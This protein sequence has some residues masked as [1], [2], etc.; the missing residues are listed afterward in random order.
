MNEIIDLW[1]DFKAEKIRSPKTIL[2][3]QADLLGKKTNNILLCELYFYP[4]SSKLNLIEFDFK[5]KAPNL[6]GYTYRLFFGDYQVHTLYPASIDFEPAKDE[7]DFV[8]LVK[9][10]LNSLE[11]IK[12]INSLYSQS[13]EEVM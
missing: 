13:L 3:E 11:N 10:N 12:V 4:S 5:I 6:G 7:K 9:K 1:P 2:K 8:E